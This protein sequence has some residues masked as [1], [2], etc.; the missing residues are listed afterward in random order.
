[1]QAEACRFA[2]QW[3]HCAVE[4]HIIQ[5]RGERIL[6]KPRTFTRSFWLNLKGLDEMPDV[7]DVQLIVNPAVFNCKRIIIRHS[8]DIKLPEIDD[9]E[10][11]LEH[12]RG[13]LGEISS[14]GQ[15]FVLDI[16]FPVVI[17]LLE[18]CRELNRARGGE[19]L[20]LEL[21]PPTQ[22]HLL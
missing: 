6:F 13:R 12:L 8:G 22:G 21:A 2:E 18:P 7:G 4:G 16:G 10:D 14:S 9:H 15:S 20:D 11:E 3:K 17:S 5:I 19:I 1:M